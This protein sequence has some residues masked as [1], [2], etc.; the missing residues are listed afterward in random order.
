MKL[1]AVTISNEKHKVSVATI[2]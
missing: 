1:Q 2:K